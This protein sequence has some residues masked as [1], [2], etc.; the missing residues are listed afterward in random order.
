MTF[1]AFIQLDMRRRNP[2][3]H[4]TLFLYTFLVGKTIIGGSVWFLLGGI[5]MASWD[6][7][8]PNR[9]GIIMN[10]DMPRSVRAQMLKVKATS[11]QSL[12]SQVVSALI[13]KW[14]FKPEDS[15][16]V[17]AVVVDPRVAQREALQRIDPLERARLERSGMRV[18]QVKRDDSCP[19]TV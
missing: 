14:G 19:W 15:P 18:Q 1:N 7:K 2:S 6:P 13:F 11:G 16:P 17:P 8:R 9:P 3:S 12:V 5:V 10:F 4:F